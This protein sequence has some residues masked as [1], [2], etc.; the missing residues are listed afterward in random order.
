VPHQ[1]VPGP[2][3]NMPA[4]SASGVTVAPP[5]SPV[6]QHVMMNEQQDDVMPP[7]PVLQQ[8]D[9]LAQ[10]LV[11]PVEEDLLHVQENFVA[12]VA[13]QDFFA[14]VQEGFVAEQ[15]APVD[16]I[17][18]FQPEDD[19]FINNHELVPQNEERAITLFV[20]S[21]A[22]QF[23]DI[24]N[25][26]DGIQAA[27]LYGS[28]LSDGP[29]DL[30]APIL[31]D[32]DG[33]R[34]SIADVQ[35]IDSLPPPV[36]HPALSDCVSKSLVFTSLPPQEEFVQTRKTATRKSKE[37]KTRAVLVDEGPR[38]FTRGSAAKEGYRVPPITDIAPKSRKRARKVIPAVRG[39]IV[40]ANL[41]TDGSRAANASGDGHSP[42]P[43][44]PIQTLQQIG[45]FLDIE[46]EL[47][48]TD[49]LTAVSG[50]DLPS[51]S[52]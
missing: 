14:A 21:I 10:Q 44:I 6:V 8:A 7:G 41:A 1:D 42:T 33:E 2:A 38:R 28:S 9:Q 12:P 50:E 47:L 34:V 35:V 52:G 22:Q 48:T 3:N 27:A 4:D 20:P 18:E 51:T 37:K 31:L 30:A 15:P 26:L 25:A 46:P 49:K 19:M 24:N 36:D 43:E 13:P 29:L 40:Q 32:L 39:D 45:Q 5:F 11:A 17:M 23:L 16:V